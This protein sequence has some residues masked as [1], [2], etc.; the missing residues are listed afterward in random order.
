MDNFDVENFVRGKLCHTSNFDAG[1]SDTGG[2]N[3]VTGKF[4]FCL[5]KLQ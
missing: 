2:E 1:P 4:L 5:T 3:L